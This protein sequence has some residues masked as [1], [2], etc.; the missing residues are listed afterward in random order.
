MAKCL[1]IDPTQ[2]Q[3]ER[4]PEYIVS[5]TLDIAENL[6]V[7]GA[8]VNRV[9]D[10][11]IRICKAYD[12]RKINVISI[13][14]FIFLSVLTPEGHI[15]NQD[16]RVYQHENDLAY[17]EDLNAL[18][19]E[20]CRDKPTVT[21]IARRIES[22]NTKQENKRNVFYEVL[23]Y[24]VGCGAFTIFFGGNILDALASGLISILL[25]AFSKRSMVPTLNRVVS[26]FLCS[27]LGGFSA[28][29]LVYLH[30]GSNLNAIIIGNIMLLVPGMILTNSIRDLLCGDTIAGLLKLIESLL[31]ALAIA[32]GYALPLL[33]IGGNL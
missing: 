10:T 13:T 11:V 28:Y 23:A 32:V 26:T 33:L 2:A 15:I 17:L 4:D 7:S 30:M 6:L 8:S 5:L 27:V 29:L 24:I 31:V 22:L 9:E 3:S 25:Y 1:C 14:E 20:I 18:S 16:R 19:R 12:Y 21:T